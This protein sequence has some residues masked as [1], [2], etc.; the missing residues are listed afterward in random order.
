MKISSPSSSFT[1]GWWTVNRKFLIVQ[2]G[3]LPPDGQRLITAKYPLRAFRM[4]RSFSV[5]EQE[6]LVDK[7]HFHTIGFSAYRKK[8]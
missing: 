3:A 8:A 1:I 6:S 5:I 2:N 4:L 7:Y